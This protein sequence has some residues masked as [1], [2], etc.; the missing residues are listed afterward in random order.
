MVD[1][2]WEHLARRFL[3]KEKLKINNPPLVPVTVYWKGRVYV[4]GLQEIFPEYS[5]EIVLLS[6]GSAPADPR[7]IN[8]LNKVNENR[9][10]VTADNDLDLT[11]RQ[12]VLRRLNERLTK[13]T[14]EQTQ[15]TEK[16]MPNI[17]E[18]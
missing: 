1:Y 15:Y 9:L 10:E 16:N 12:H 13:M 5:K 18:L 3:E 4:G 14:P 2:D 17:C 7:M 6:K 11:G 8:A